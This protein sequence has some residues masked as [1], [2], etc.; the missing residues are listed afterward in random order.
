MKSRKP[1]K[2]SQQQKPKRSSLSPNQYT[3]IEQGEIKK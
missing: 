1:I 2:N 3:E